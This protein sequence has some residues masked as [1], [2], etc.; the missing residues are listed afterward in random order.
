MKNPNRHDLY[1]DPVIKNVSKEQAR[2][3]EQKLI[4]ECNTLIPDKL[5]PSHNQINGVS[6]SNKNYQFYWDM[7]VTYLEE[8][9][10]LCTKPSRIK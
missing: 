3:L 6:L 9:V 4:V 8:N 7:A 1:F 5:N 2:G 10:V